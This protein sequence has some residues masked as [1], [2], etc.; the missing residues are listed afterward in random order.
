[1]S[2]KSQYLLGIL[3]RDNVDVMLQNSDEKDCQRKLHQGTFFAKTFTQKFG[4]FFKE[5]RISYISFD[6][7]AS[8]YA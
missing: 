4:F 2:M 1:M 5:N 3:Q 7:T 8:F 6:K